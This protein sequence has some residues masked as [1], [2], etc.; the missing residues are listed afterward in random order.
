VTW[1][2]GV[3]GHLESL[4]RKRRSLNGLL[5]NPPLD[6]LAG[7]AVAALLIAT[8]WLVLS[9]ID[10]PRQ[11]G[12]WGR[13]VEAFGTP[14][15]LLAAVILTMSLASYL[16]P[17]FEFQVDSSPPTH[18]RRRSLFVGAFGAL[19]IGTLAGLIVTGLIVLL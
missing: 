6:M 5:S 12:E 16:F 19:L 8:L 3:A 18:M 7:C 2:K 13:E 9:A 1:V 4:L 14:V 15:L 17:A 11:S 10:A